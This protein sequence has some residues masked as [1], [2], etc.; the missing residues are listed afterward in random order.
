[1]IARFLPVGRTLTTFAPGT[2][3]MPW[4]RF[5]VADAVAACVWAVYAS[6]L[7]YAGGA[8]FE[9]SLWKPLLLSLGVAGALSLVTEA[10]RRFRKRRGRDLLAGQLR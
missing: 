6:M 9:H 4:K 1:V 7:G 8:G 2:L 5:V 3:G 10:Y